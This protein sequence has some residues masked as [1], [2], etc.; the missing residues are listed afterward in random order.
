MKVKFSRKFFGELA[1]GIVFLAAIYFVI[2]PGIASGW[3]GMF[4]PA[5]GLLLGY[6]YPIL[7]AAENI[8]WMAAIVAAVV[9]GESKDKRGVVAAPVLFILFWLV[10]SIE[11]RA[12][13]QITERQSGQTSPNLSSIAKDERT[14]IFDNSYELHPNILASGVIDRLV[15]IERDNSY[16]L[17]GI[18]MTIIAHG[19]QCSDLEHKLSSLRSI[20]RADD[21]FKKQRLETIPDGLIIAYRYNVDFV[22]GK[23]GCCNELNV[24]RREKG[25]ED[26]LFSLRQGYANVLSYF[27]HWFPQS[28]AS[29]WIP[30]NLSPTIASLW[31]ASTG[32]PLQPVGYGAEIEPTAMVAI[33]GVDPKAPLSAMVESAQLLDVAQALADTNA[34]TQSLANNDYEA[35]LALLVEAQKRRITDLRAIKIAASLVGHESDFNLSMGLD[36]Y[37]SALTSEQTAQLLDATLE[38]L[39]TPGI[40]NNCRS[41]PLSWTFAIARLDDPTIFIT[42]AKQVLEDRPNLDT[43]QYEAALRLL[44]AM[45]P[46]N[47]DKDFLD[48]L[49]QRLGTDAPGFANRKEAFQRVFRQDLPSH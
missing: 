29:F 13:I 9:Y 17:L 8:I 7:I 44:V 31:Q 42:K 48:D 11:T 21:C 1:S 49:R 47:N 39:A 35:A 34:S 30:G 16:K 15:H 23:R 41:S 3:R 40:C 36:R 37:A 5:A 22:H 27:P 28:E 18:T 14:L 20:G 46:R 38:R 10:A 32:S 6:V 12:Q 26:R 33:Y 4:G 19:E 25:K 24:T 2:M 45:A 43:W